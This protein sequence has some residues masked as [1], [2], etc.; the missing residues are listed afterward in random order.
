MRRSLHRFFFIALL[1]VLASQAQ[2]L[3]A[4]TLPPYYNVA[5]GTGTNAFPWS[6]STGKGIQWIVNPGEL[7]SPTPAPGGNNITHIW[8]Y[9]A[10]TTNATYTNFSVQLG[11]LP[12]NSDPAWTAA[13]IYSGPMTTV[14]VPGTKVINTTAGTWVSMQLDTVFLYDPSQALVVYVSQC[15]F[16]GTSSQAAS[17]FTASGTR[18]KYL[19]PASCVQAYAGQDALMSPI[20]VTLVPAGPCTAP[21][22]A[23]NSTVSNVSPCMGASISLNLSGNSM[24]GGQTYQWQ[25]STSLSGPWTSITTAASSSSATVTANASGITYYRAIVTCNSQVDSSTPV[26][27]NVAPPFPAGTYTID[28][29]QPAS[30][31]NF[32]SFSAAA[33]AINCAIAGPIVFNVAPGTYTNDQFILNSI[34]TSSTNTVTIN[35]NGATMSFLSSNPSQRGAFTLNGT[36]HITVNNLNIIATGSSTSEYGSGV[37]LSNNAD[38]NTFSNLNIRVDTVGTSTNYIPVVISGSLTSPTTAGS[39]CD[40]NTFTGCTL[41]GGYYNMVIYGNASAPLI[42]DNTITNNVIKN[43][44]AYGI[45]LYGNNAALVEGNNISRPTRTTSTTFAGVIFSGVNTNVNFSKNRIHNAFD[46]MATSTSAAY[47]IYSSSSDATLGNE[48]VISNNL[49]YD[50]NHAGVIYGIYNTGSDYYKYY[51]NTISLDDLA[52]TTSSATRGFYQT[53]S[54]TG[55]DFRN[56]IISIKRGGT[57]INHGIYMGTAATTYSSNYN[58]VY[59]SGAGTNYF[60]Y[61]GA[62]QAT[63]A[64][65]QAA[66]TKDSNSY[67]LPNFFSNTATGDYTPG[68]A[69]IDN[70]GTFLGITTDILNNTRSVTTPDIGAYEF[71]V[72]LCTGIPSPGTATINGSSSATVCNGSNVGLSL[73]GFT[74][75]NGIS[76]QWESSPAGQATW[77]AITGATNPTYNAQ[78]TAATD[79]R[80]V[81]TCSNGGGSDVS[82]TVTATLSPFYV[83]YCSP[84]T[85]T[86]LHTS[87]AN[88]TTN[89]AIPGTSL[90][91]T[92]TAVGPGGYTF[93]NPSVSSNTATLAQGV[94]YTINVTESTTTA[95]SEVWVDWDQNGTFDATEYYQ[96]VKT[97]LIASGTITP[98]LT[99]T[100][101]LT[102]MRVR[103]IFSTTVTYGASGA[104]SNPS[105]GRETEDY[106]ITIAPPPTCFP[107]SGIT[108]NSV[109]SSSVTFSWTASNPAPANG[110]DYYYSTTNT[111]PTNSTSPSGS[112]GTGV[113]T[114]TI[115]GLTPVTTYYV[116]VRGNCGPNDYSV[117]SGPMSFTTACAAFTAPYTHDVE[118]QT[119]NTNS[120]MTNCWTSLPTN[121]SAYAWHVTGNGTTSSGS[122]GP[123]TAHSGVKYFYTEASNGTTNDVAT[124]TTPI[125]N[126][127]TLTTPMLQFWYHMYGATINKLV[128]EVFN[129]TTWNPVDSILGQQQTSETAPWA[130]RNII[131]SGYTGNIQARFVATRGTS[132]T[133]DISIDDISFVQAPS[134]P[135][136]ATLTATTTA[137]T[138]TL[139]WTE[140]GTATQWQIDYGVSTFTQGSGTLVTT[141]TNPHSLTGLSS[142]T[143]YKFYV[144]SICGANDTSAWSGPLVFATIPPND[145]C[146][147]AI[148]ITNGQVYNGTTAG[149]TQTMAPCDATVTANDVWYTFTTGSVAGNVTVSVNTTT[150]GT[151][152]VLSVYSG[153]CGALTV[154]TPTTSSGT[155]TCIDG[156]AAGNEFGTYAVAANTTYYVR[157]YGYLGMQGAF[158]I[159]AT[160]TPLSIKLAS[161]TA[162][163]AGTRNRVDWQTAEEVSGDQFI[164]ERSADGRDFSALTTINAKGQASSYTYWD[165]SPVAGTN[166]YRLKLMDAAGTASYS[167][168]VTAVVKS[169]SFIVE[170]YPNPVKEKLVIRVFGDQGANGKV[171]ITD[172]TGKVVRHLN[173]STSETTIDMSGLAQ[174]IYLV[175]Y[176]D[177]HHR[178]TI[179]VN[180]L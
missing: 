95:N 6:T 134:C 177:D 143:S 52:S 111:N 75:G 157:V 23:G 54:A 39:N 159:Q 141:T 147:N 163:N 126:V 130:Q 79:Y 44:Y 137:T 67:E 17:T 91:N 87:T 21:P 136:P 135:A 171:E 118:A 73:S 40:G 72:P 53:T 93:A 65:W 97:N 133:G 172:A 138:A 34:N 56:N 92:T 105:T 100:L 166:Y 64:A 154:M 116:W 71:T 149:A 98:P 153:T 122:T 74:T 1:I 150:T 96:L 15:G 76:L 29:T 120:V 169:G 110:Y 128:I 155:G 170:A 121:T 131:L 16:T 108:S 45:Y 127:S 85:G 86:T 124:L 84:S 144:R 140:L 69:S 83:C 89:V 145:T 9:I 158:P 173:A 139:G 22:T 43:F 161:I 99:A 4:Q 146:Q 2:S 175:K 152:I 117:W 42:A 61:S 123:S 59:V 70:V 11:Q 109:T 77:S 51:H 78:V 162:T 106:V 49:V 115:S 57:G 58:N 180:K 28:N 25:S 66:T 107:P 167:K 3:S 176:S 168:V 26:S 165:E 48:N 10:S 50:I 24:G 38:S 151:D 156:P 82:N 88:Y 112:V 31:T 60:G 33:A 55:L 20:G 12:S 5:T 104:C 102:G 178:E 148:D 129:G 30:A 13:S 94:P 101:G 174:G 7:S 68:N 113:T 14:I 18:R 119:A 27:I 81:I 36:D 37:Y 63:L 47:P 90:N 160:G 179:K 32:P 125:V 114:A 142:G 35:G 46:M 41:N 19:T 8:F 103:T 62:N 80:A 132:F 164:V